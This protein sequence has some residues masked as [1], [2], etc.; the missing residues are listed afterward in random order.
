MSTI[1]VKTA[2]RKR[3]RELKNA[4][5]DD[6]LRYVAELVTNADDSYKRLGDDTD[7]PK[8][9]KIELQ[10]D[11]R[12]KDGY[13]I[14]VTD[15]AEGMS[16]ERLEKIFG[17]YA[18]DNANGMDFHARGI[19]GQGASDVLQ[20]SAMEHRTARIESIK[21]N[22][23]SKL[24]Y[25]MDENLIASIQT[26]SLSLS[27]NR[28]QQYRDSINIPKNGTK[29]TFGIPSNVKFNKRI[30]ENLPEAISKYYS[31]RYLLNQSNRHV[32]FK[33]N[34]S[35]YLLSSKNYQFKSENQLLDED[36][37]FKFDDKTINCSLK[38]YLNNNKKNDG[39]HIIVRD[40]NYIIYDNTMFDFQNSSSAQN[41]SGELVI[42]GLYEICHRHLN[43]TENPDAIIHDNRTGFDTKNQFYILLNKSINP[44]IDRVLRENSKEIKI[45]NLNNNKKFNDA[46]KK[47]NKYLKSELNDTIGGGNLIGKV[48]PIEGIK[49][50]R[51]NI[52][53]TKDKQYDLKLLINS[54]LVPSGQSVNIICEDNN[55]EFTPSK[56]EYSLSEIV[57]GLVIKNVTIKGKNLT[58]APIIMRANTGARTA[59]VTIEVIDADIH[60]PD[61]GLEF[62]PNNVTLIEGKQH[63]VKLYIDSNVIP[64]DSSISIISNELE[65]PSIIRWTRDNL[66]NEKIG[67]LNVP[68]NGGQKNQTY[69]VCASYNNV[70]SHVSVTIIEA[71]KNEPQSGGLISGFKLEPNEMF[72]QSYFNPHDHF[73]YINSS[74]FINEKIMGDLSDKNPDSPT[75]NSQQ[76]K[77]LCD[78]I[79]HEAASYLVKQRNIRNGEVNFDNFENAVEQ[80]QTLIQKEKNK[81]YTQIYAAIMGISEESKD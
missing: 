71:S 69:D 34:D 24:T 44:L 36:F 63:F 7:V 17:T 51:N 8:V 73:I 3:K 23:V 42:N 45:T 32:Y 52:S 9:I 39:T 64:L 70:T 22:Q 6:I 25:N 27:G 13:M 81:I 80:V 2:L 4:L 66:I 26:E 57:D 15:N 41:V 28:L 75:F 60:Y 48:P 37:S 1:V 12:F 38:L 79:S 18:D 47:L 29:V 43:D 54:N 61:G 55:V 33:Y 67:V 72:F 50:V 10:E 58:V 59:T 76:S 78:I 21:D 46:L 62:Y 77:Y 11:K 14:S 5:G 53:I 31:F 40:E 30:I 35:I 65:C 68:L 19:F 74:N 56:L 16:I 49:F 20:S